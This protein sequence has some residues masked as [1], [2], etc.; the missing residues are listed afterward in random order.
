MTPLTPEQIADNGSA[1]RT[2]SA[3]KCDRAYYAGGFCTTH[4]QRFKKYGDPYKVHKRPA[5]DRFHEKY[6]VSES[7]CWLWKDYKNHGGYP[8]FFPG[9]GNRKRV[10]LAHR[11][12]YATFAGP[13]PEGLHID[14]ICRVRSC[15]N[16]KHLQTID[17]VEHGKLTTKLAGWTAKTREEVDELLK[18]NTA[19]LRLKREVVLSLIERIR[20][21]ESRKCSHGD[22]RMQGTTDCSNCSGYCAGRTEYYVIGEGLCLSCRNSRLSGKG[23]L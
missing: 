20:E 7:G 17:P 12:S 18:L 5:L 16:P 23:G 2:C 10:H 21:L 22:Y 4:Y 8:T 14:H 1:V 19:A 3:D 11:W 9:D 15:V 6:T 13:I